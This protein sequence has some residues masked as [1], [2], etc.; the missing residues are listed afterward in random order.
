[1]S[2]QLHPKLA[3]DLDYLHRRSLGMDLRIVLGTV[4]VILHRPRPAPMATVTPDA[5]RL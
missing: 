5:A 1:V 4:A 3:V 2:S